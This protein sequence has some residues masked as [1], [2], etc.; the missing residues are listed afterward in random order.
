[1]RHLEYF[2]DHQRIEGMLFD[3]VPAPQNGALAPDAGRPGM[4]LVLK[5]Q[6]AAKFAVD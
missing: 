2:Y 1:M 5:R 4:G 3:G 6:D